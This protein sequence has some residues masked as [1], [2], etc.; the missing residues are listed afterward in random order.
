MTHRVS[1]G[2]AEQHEHPDQHG[3]RDLVVVGESAQPDESEDDDGQADQAHATAP[4]QHKPPEERDDELQPEHEDNTD[5]V[6][7]RDKED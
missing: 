3:Q 5:G 4:G 1:R 7:D 6:V 2:K